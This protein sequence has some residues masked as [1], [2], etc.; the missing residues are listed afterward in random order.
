MEK[1][2]SI[3]LFSGAG[4]LAL[5]LHAAG[6]EHKALFEWNISA[7]ETLQYNQSMGHHALKNCSISRA[8]VRDVDFR[9][10]RG[11]DL[12]AGG[13]PCQPFSM[14]GKAAGMKD[15][16]DMFPQAVRAVSEVRPRAFIFENVRGLLRPA[17]ANYVEYIRL[18][19][20][21]PSFSTRTGR[22]S[23]HWC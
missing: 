3:E 20:E 17:F 12:V 19:M 21:F 2:E 23:L 1:L 4:G 6:F 7:I 22:R 8:D 11:I 16:R 9:P 5:G 18:Q 15:T 14:G 13:P 10:F